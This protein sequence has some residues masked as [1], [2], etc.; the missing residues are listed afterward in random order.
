MQ[1]P[2]FDFRQWY[3]TELTTIEQ[4]EE[5]FFN[6]KVDGELF[7]RGMPNYDFVCISSFYRYFISCRV[8]N[9]SEVDVGF[10]SKV[11]LPEIDLDEYKRL[12]FQILDVF[13]DNLRKLGSQ[14]LSFETVAYLAQHYGLPTDLIDF[15]YDPKIALYFACCEMP[16]KDCSVYM[17]DIYSRVKE[18]MELYASGAIGYCKK[19]NGSL[20][21]PSERADHA[22][23]LCTKLSRN[24]LSTVT[25]VIELDKI[26]YG[27]R[28]LN[29]KGAFIYHRDVVPMDQL[30][31][32]ASTDPYYPGRRVYKI[33]NKLKPTI[34]RRLESKFGINEVFVYPNADQNLDIIDTAV[35]MTKS[36][37]EL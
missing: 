28:I 5:A 11:L 18:M 37:L 10:N 16:E 20:M 27:Q 29:Q 2:T 7:F 34:L 9:W 15:S 23:E 36:K 21:E 13:Y 6:K 31:Y 25:P 30:M 3:Q 24:G 19:P 26:K 1:F 14:E 33:P 17:F 12:S 4:I 32:T 35:K 8:L 22:R